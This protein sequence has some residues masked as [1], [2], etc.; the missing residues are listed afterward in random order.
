[1]TG[2]SDDPLLLALPGVAPPERGLGGRLDVRTP[3][4]PR[5]G[6]GKAFM[7]IVFRIVLP[8]EFTAGPSPMALEV[9][10]NLGRAV[11]LPPG[12]DGRPEDEGARS[13][14]L[15]PPPTRRLE[16]VGTIPTLFRV[17]GRAG[18]AAVGGP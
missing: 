15:A 14:L 11:L 13:P 6:C 1:V 12:V 3:I 2:L 18:N 17:F 5:G 9:V 8:A 16:T 10:R 7:L 4:T